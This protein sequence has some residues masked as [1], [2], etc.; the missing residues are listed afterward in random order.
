MPSISSYNEYGEYSEG[1]EQIA[2][3]E[4]YTDSREK[5]AVDVCLMASCHRPSCHAAVHQFMTGYAV[6]LDLC[7][8]LSVSRACICAWVFLVGL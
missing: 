5:E 2:C 8:N 6:S 7:N 1:H 3:V 4:A